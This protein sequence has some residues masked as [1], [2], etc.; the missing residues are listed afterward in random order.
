MCGDEVSDRHMCRTFSHQSHRFQVINS[1]RVCFGWSIISC[2]HL[3]SFK[4]LWTPPHLTRARRTLLRLNAASVEAS[5]HPTALALKVHQN[6][7]TDDRATHPYT[8]GSSSEYSGWRCWRARRPP[9]AA[10]QCFGLLPD[11][12]GLTHLCRRWGGWLSPARRFRWAPSLTG[13][14]REESE[15]GLVVVE[16]VEVEEVMRS[17]L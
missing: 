9:S 11:W 3:Q 10:P 17:C 1:S 5:F 7:N 14:T 13:S 12:A 8:A 4:N 6:T 15:G 2:A 16:E